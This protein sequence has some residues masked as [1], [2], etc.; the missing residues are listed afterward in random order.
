MGKMQPD[1]VF[2]IAQFFKKL[3]RSLNPSDKGYS[4]DDLPAKL[5]ENLFLLLHSFSGFALLV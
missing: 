1:K 2:S 5:P 4:D 3:A